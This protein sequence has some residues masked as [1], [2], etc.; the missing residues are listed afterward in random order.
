M[1]TQQRLREGMTLSRQQPCNIHISIFT[2]VYNTYLCVSTQAFTFA[3]AITGG[4][5]G[6]SGTEA[7]GVTVTVR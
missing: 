7:V 5:G 6:G 1:E 2:H 3:G 4:H